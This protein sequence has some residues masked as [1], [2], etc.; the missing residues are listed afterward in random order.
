MQ[1]TLSK[2]IIYIPTFTFLYQFV[3]TT[4]HL[5]NIKIKLTSSS[6]EEF[7]NYALFTTLE[8]H[9]IPMLNFNIFTKQSFH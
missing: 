6:T 2:H 7:L 3:P 8:I 9:S 4:Q 5:Q 1:F